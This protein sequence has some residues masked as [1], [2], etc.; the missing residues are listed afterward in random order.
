MPAS[1][2]QGFHQA[3]RD[4]R[5]KRLRQPATTL[6]YSRLCIR[7]S[8]VSNA[9]REE[10]SVRRKK[11]PCHPLVSLLSFSLAFCLLSSAQTVVPPAAADAQTIPSPDILGRTTPRGTVLGFLK[12][13]RKGDYDAATEYLNT[14]RRGEAATDLARELFVIIDRRLPA[15]LNRLSDRPE[16]SLAFPAKPDQDLVGTISS[17]SGN[18]DLLLE[19]VDRDGRRIWLFSAPTLNSVHALY[20]EMDLES[21]GSKLPD[22]L[23]RIRIARIPLLHWLAVLVGLPLFCLVTVVLDRLLSPLAGRW[24]RTLRGNPNL[25]DPKVLPVALRVLLLVGA[26]RWVSAKTGMPLIERQVWSTVASILAIAACVS[27]FFALTGWTERHIRRR[28]LRS[29]LAAR[30]SILRLARWAAN[31]LAV[32]VALM[33]VLY[34]LGANPNATLAGL[35]V[36]GIAVAL[37]A[38]KTLENVIGGASIIFDGAVRVGDLLRVGE[39]LGTVEDIGLRS[40]RLRTFDRTVFTVPNGQ[41]ANVS[42][43]NLSLRDSFWFHHIFSLRYETTAL[44][45]RSVLQGITGLLEKYPLIKYFP[46]PVRFLRLSAYSLDVEIFAH[47]AVSDLGRFLELQGQLLLEIME[48]IEAAGVRLAIPA[49]TAYLAVSSGF[50]RSSVDALLDPSRPHGSEQGRNAA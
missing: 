18:I 34:C 27:I 45:M 39:T 31:L 9:E 8:R 49:Q 12:A 15:R 28:L 38:Q 42:L 46:T 17:K 5:M 4:T 1:S 16:G 10:L 47:L 11:A 50:D 44:Q 37:A 13:A 41:I 30:A 29:D 48:V 43:E 2:T 33:A 32:F 21:S 19:R 40:I 3:S 6:P 25:P 26:I 24:R 20:T 7:Q 14:N 35:G 36:G 22:F 23:T